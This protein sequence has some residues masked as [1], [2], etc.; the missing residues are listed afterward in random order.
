MSNEDK[1]VEQ[2]TAPMI[3][4]FKKSKS[5]LRRNRSNW[6]RMNRPSKLEAMDKGASFINSVLARAGI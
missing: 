2:L 4:Q 1:L 5:F 6:K 3:Q